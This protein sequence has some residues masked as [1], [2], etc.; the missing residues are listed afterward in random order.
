MAQG[1]H[2]IRSKMLPQYTLIP[3]RDTAQFDTSVHTDVSEDNSVS[4]YVDVD[5]RSL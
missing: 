5:K 4:V 2:A 1:L 3:T